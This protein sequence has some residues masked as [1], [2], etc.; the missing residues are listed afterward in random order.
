MSQIQESCRLQKC[1]C[2]V[3]RQANLVLMICIANLCTRR[4]NQ[5]SIILLY[6]VRRSFGIEYPN[7]LS[8]V[9]N[10]KHYQVSMHQIYQGLGVRCIYLIIRIS[11]LYL[12][13]N[14]HPHSVTWIQCLIICVA[15]CYTNLWEGLRQTFT[16]YQSK[17]VLHTI[18]SS[19]YNCNGKFGN[20]HESKVT[21]INR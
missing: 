1:Y 14:N 17:Q 16:L 9:Y 10:N 20:A 12:C 7:P 13:V 11:L 19:V 3:R 4:N 5:A 8:C 18:I 21:I 15:T 6:T 2:T